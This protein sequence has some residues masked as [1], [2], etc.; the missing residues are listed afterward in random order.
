[1]G[2]HRTVAR[3][4]LATLL[5]NWLTSTMTWLAIG[6]ALALPA[7][8]Y[9]ILVNVGNVSGEWEGKPR[10][11]LYLEDNVSSVDGKAFAK[12]I[13]DR[14]TVES[15][16]YVSAE[17]A[18]DEFKALSGFGE[19]VDSLDDNPL[20]AVIIVAP[21]V[22]EPARLK[23][24]IAALED[25]NHVTSASMDLK[26][27]ERLY[28]IIGFGQRL[29]AALGA[30]LALGVLLII[31]NTIRLAIENRRDEIEVVKLVGGTD[32]FVRRPFLYLG[33]WYGLGGAIIA[34]LL[35]Q[36]SL[37]FLAAPVQRLV[38][39]YGN[40]FSISGLGVTESLV[41][42]TGGSILGVLGALLAVSRHLHEIEP[43]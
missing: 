11:T 8:L 10:I 38:Q 24:I 42:W 18:L 7:I 35:V 40:Q 17:E 5:R 31:G 3:E 25:E 27:I 32:A 14:E 19:V 33:L 30:F 43:H 16:H 2:H 21:A 13:E 41:L 12:E 4:S 37:M 15:T 22:S 26:W 29:V 34:W 9:L 36:I 23:L 39:S 1:M 6:I 20:P 28:A